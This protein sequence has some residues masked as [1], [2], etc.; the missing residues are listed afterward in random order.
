MKFWKQA[1]ILMLLL[2]CLFYFN[3]DAQ[4]K[5]SSA[6]ISEEK[7]QPSQEY[8]DRRLDDLNQTMIASINVRKQYINPLL[9][10]LND[11][12]PPCAE[13]IDDNTALEEL[14][15]INSK[16][17]KPTD[18]ITFLKVEDF[19][20]LVKYATITPDLEKQIQEAGLGHICFW[21]TN[22]T[23][24]EAFLK[25][26]E[27]YPCSEAAVIALMKMG[28]LLAGGQ[29]EY[30]TSNHIAGYPTK[31]PTQ[32]F[33]YEINDLYNF[34]ISKYPN[35]WEAESCKTRLAVRNCPSQKY[36]LC[37]EAIQAIEEYLQYKEENNVFYNNIL[38]FH[39]WPRRYNNG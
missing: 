35:T 8:I 15:A 25:I 14:K 6:G 23:T 36:P 13:V 30:I 37:D 28:D 31:E 7:S 4:V 16:Q 33:Y 5:P 18:F 39:G 11:D 17:E 12:F 24:I 19:Q 20:K 2:N 22:P 21:Y 26:W 9:E 34:I 3:G 1:A 38:H 32:P 27:K 29:R 10:R